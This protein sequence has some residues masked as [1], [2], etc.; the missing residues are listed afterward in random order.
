[1]LRL[2]AGALGGALAVGA[3]VAPAV[4][5]AAPVGSA[6]VSVD[7][8]P[9]RAVAAGGT[10]EGAARLPEGRSRWRVS[11]HAL[12]AVTWTG[13]APTVELR[14]PG[15]RWEAWEPLA[16]LGESSA[17]EGTEPQWVGSAGT[18]AVRVEGGNGTARLTVIDPGADPERQS[19]AGGRTAART[20]RAA[21]PK[22]APRPEIHTRKDWGANERWRNGK[23]RYNA[24]LKQ[25][26]IHHTAGTND[27]KRKE[28]R[29]II[30]AIYRYHTHTLGWSDIGYNFLVDRFG[31]A[32]VGRAGGAAKL[33]RGAHTLGFNHASTGIAVIGNFEDKSPRA[34]VVT[35]L[36]RLSAW[37]LDKAG[38][39]PQGKIWVTSKGSDLFA[40][41]ERVK[42][43]VIDGH[44]DTNQTAC[45]GQLLYDL[46]PD[47][48]KRAAHRVDRFS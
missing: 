40:K 10:R 21:A 7:R 44:R 30:R 23:P 11:G 41:G 36:V 35:M 43:P 19:A 26:H 16:D 25:V 22:R 3:A 32:W 33:V 38:L 13:A 24:K 48:R 45:P 12:L 47:I 18:V 17:V 1:M 8:V 6:A 46:L 15:G 9:L 34:D 2:T 4:G 27:Y 37:K 5:V 31:R 20:G 42:L 29:G 14:L 39:D 28:V